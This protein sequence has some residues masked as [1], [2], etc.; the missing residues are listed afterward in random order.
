[1]AIVRRL[2]YEESRQS[3]MCVVTIL[4]LRNKLSNDTL[5]SLDPE[6]T[7]ENVLT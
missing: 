1:M 7:I 2:K 6:S 4:L 5:F 3:Q